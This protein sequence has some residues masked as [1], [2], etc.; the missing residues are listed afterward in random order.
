ME[1]EVWVISLG[2]S[3]IVPNEVDI[4]FL[5]NFKKLI[6]S[7]PNKKFIVV[8]GG[9]K[10]SRTYASAMKKIGKSTGYQ[11]RIGIA[12]TRFHAEYL[13]KMFGKSANHA[14]PKTIK[15]T[16]NLLDKN[17]IVFTGALRYSKEQTS[18][19]VAAKIAAQ[20]GCPFINLTNI[21]GLFS[22][23]PKTNKNAKFIERISWK[24][25]YK[26]TSKIKYSAGQHF[27]LDQT[28]SRIIMDKKI[29]TYIV[30]SLKQ[31]NNIL[32][33]KKFIGTLIEG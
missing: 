6:D 33:K 29:S 23:N 17:H 21:K 12:V 27:V 31:I 13:M 1:K 4:E 32:K 9:G 26:K 14:L 25:F 3:R 22:S 19:S 30:G 20:L 24:N 8:T 18:D 16:I 11:S 2:G 15:K 28:A 5:Q 7:N 10:T